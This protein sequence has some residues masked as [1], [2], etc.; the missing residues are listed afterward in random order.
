M[1]SWEPNQLSSGIRKMLE[2]ISLF[3]PVKPTDTWR[4]TDKEREGD[5]PQA[6]QASNRQP[7]P[8]LS[9][10]TGWDDDDYILLS[11]RRFGA[12]KRAKG[13]TF[14]PPRSKVMTMER[15]KHWSRKLHYLARLRDLD[16]ES[17]SYCRHTPSVFLSYDLDCL[18]NTKYTHDLG[19]KK[20][21][22]LVCINNCKNPKR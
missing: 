3:S 16:L 18:E 17:S 22:N 12:G 20:T 7:P 15:R 10:M 4:R 9:L 11:R 21:W 8:S 13:I 6:V 2:G 1:L 19:R 14:N 5:G